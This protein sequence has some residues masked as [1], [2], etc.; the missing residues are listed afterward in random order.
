MT[1]T[2]TQWETWT[3]L[4]MPSSGQYIIPEGLSVLNIDREK[5]LGTYVEP[6]IW[7]QHR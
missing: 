1:G 2:V 7:M 3:K 4:A 6:N 5:D